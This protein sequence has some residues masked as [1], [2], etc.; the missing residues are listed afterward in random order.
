MNAHGRFG[1]KFA[2]PSEPKSS[3]G[4]GEGAVPE[5]T[6]A[7]HERKRNHT[8]NRLTLLNLEPPSPRAVD[9]LGS[10]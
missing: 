3:S 10:R 4:D 9:H 1:L 5:E 7:F 6:L 2:F 8:Y